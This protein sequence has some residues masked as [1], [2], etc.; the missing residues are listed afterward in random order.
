VKYPTFHI[1]VPNRK[2]LGG[3][4]EHNS[5]RQ[6]LKIFWSKEPIEKNNVNNSHNISHQNSIIRMTNRLVITNIS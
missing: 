3:K 1:I 2:D 6:E 4:T 5:T